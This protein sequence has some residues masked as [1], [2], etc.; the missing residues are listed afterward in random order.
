MAR[1][2][3]RISARRAVPPI[4]R[5]RIT[6]RGLEKPSGMRGQVVP[7]FAGGI[8]GRHGRHLPFAFGKAA[9]HRASKRSALEGCR[10]ALAPCHIPE[11]WRKLLSK[12]FCSFVAPPR[13]DLRSAGSSPN[14]A[15]HDPR[16][17]RLQALVTQPMRPG[18]LHVWRAGSAW[19]RPASLPRDSGATSSARHADPTGRRAPPPCRTRLFRNARASGRTQ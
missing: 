6:F 3:E 13:Y 16:Q 1:R 17:A 14:D 11:P 8:A 9:T 15:Y 12:R 7:G 2:G 4:S 5:K 18:L 19:H 10:I